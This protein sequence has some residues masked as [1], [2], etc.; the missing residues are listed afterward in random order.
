MPTRQPPAIV[1]DFVP[2]HC[3]HRECAAH[4]RGPGEA[5]RFHRRGFQRIERDPGWVRIFQ[6][7]HCGRYFRDSCFGPEYWARRSGLWAPVFQGLV[8]GQAKR[9]IAR[10]LGISRSC[11]DRIE[12]G[13]ARQCLLY[14]LKQLRSLSG[15]IAEPTVLDGFRC[16]AGSQYEP[17]DLNTLATCES[18]FLLHVEAAPLR[19]SGRMT[20]RQKAQRSERDRRLGRP[21][22]GVRRRITRKALRLLERLRDPRVP[23][24]W[25]TDE[26]PDYRRALADLGGRVEVR[27]V[28]I[29][30][31]ARRDEGNPLW[32]INL[33]HLLMRH[34]LKSH[35]RET[36][37]HHKCLRA[38]MDRVLILQCW[39]NNVKGISE[40]S[41]G[42]SRTTPAMLLGLADAPLDP[43]QLFARR[44]FPRREQLPESMVELYEGRIKARPREQ[45]SVAEPVFA[46]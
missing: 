38:L 29:S 12:R 26:E 25:R 1:R 34:S 10:A 21:E 7:R 37:A 45:I 14:T 4:V 5:F 30:S 22:R 9:Q 17:L 46:Y 15:S 19:R 27:H 20:P 6:C 11:V 3:P 31:R 42:K 8:N 23:A 36:I 35:T 28:T 44:L 24:E 43:E 41:A 32:R 2:P 18:G 16:F 13:L 40:R 33:L 39:L